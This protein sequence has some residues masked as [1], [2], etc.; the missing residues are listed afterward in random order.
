MGLELDYRVIDG[1]G[2]HMEYLRN[3]VSPELKIGDVTSEKVVGG[4]VPLHHQDLWK[5]YKFD[6]SSAGLEGC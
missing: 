3:G 1:V 5:K 4:S 6:H 2:G